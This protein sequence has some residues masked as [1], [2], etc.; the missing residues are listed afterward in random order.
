M[1]G[2]PGFNQ[3]PPGRIVL[4]SGRE[5][6]DAVKVVG[7]HHHR[8]DHKWSPGID[9]AKSLLNEINGRFIAEQSSSQRGDYSEKVS[10]ARY[11]RSPILHDPNRNCRVTQGEPSR[12]DERSII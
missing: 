2:Y 1:F 6:P 7:Q 8:V 10:A 4:I 12:S 9:V 11:E 5:S 3:S